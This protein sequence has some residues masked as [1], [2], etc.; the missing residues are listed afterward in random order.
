MEIVYTNNNTQSLATIHLSKTL[1]LYLSQRASSIKLSK[2]IDGE[3]PVA[4][5]FLHLEKG[6]GFSASKEFSVDFDEVKAEDFYVVYL[7]VDQKAIKA[8]AKIDTIDRL[9][10]LLYDWLEATLELAMIK[11]KYFEVE[12]FS[13]I[14]D[15]AEDDIWNKIKCRFFAKAKFYLVHESQWTT[16][17]NTMLEVLSKDSRCKQYTPFTSH[18]RLHLNN[19][20]KSLP[21]YYILPTSDEKYLV[22]RQSGMISEA[23]QIA[24]IF[25]SLEQALVF[26]L[27]VLKSLKN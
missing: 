15:L 25:D 13:P 23:S 27:D 17:Y 26:Y 5:A 8:R 4:N 3:L 21:W 16:Q 9:A 7:N 6:R 19:E 11:E 14:K 12:C 2:C 18:Y 24:E 22:A 20:E 1:Q 10:D